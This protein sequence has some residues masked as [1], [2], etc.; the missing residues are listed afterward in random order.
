MENEGGLSRTGRGKRDGIVAVGEGDADETAVIGDGGSGGRRWRGSPS[1]VEST[2]SVGI[3]PESRLESVDGGDSELGNFFEH[4]VGKVETT[5][6][7][8]WI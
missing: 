2:R 6:A 1:R 5:M 3:L 7:T 8:V 4:L